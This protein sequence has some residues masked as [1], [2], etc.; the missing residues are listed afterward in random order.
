MANY[1]R[2]NAWNN[3]GT[4][5]SNDDLYWYAKGV[6]KMMSRELD[7]K[8][9]WWFY[10]GIHDVDF[11]MWA[12]VNQQ[13]DIPL[14]PKPDLATQSEFW[15]QC[16]HGT[17]YFL[18]WHRGYLMALEK[19]LRTDILSLGGPATWALPYWN[20]FGGGMENHIP[21]AFAQ[22]VLIDRETGE[23][24]ANPLYVLRRFG[25]EN[26]G[27]VYMPIGN[28]GR[29]VNLDCQTKELFTNTSRVTEY[30]GG[31]TGFAH[32]GSSTGANESNPHNNGHV[33]VGGTQTDPTGLM[34]YN[35]FAAMDPIFYMHHCE[36]DR[37]WA[38]W[39]GSGGKNPNVENWLKGPAYSGGRSFVM[40]QPDG[41]KW[42][43][44]PEDVTSLESLNYTYDDLNPVV[45]VSKFQLLS[46][47]LNKL[48]I[49]HDTAL[50][51]KNTEMKN[52]PDA[53]LLGSHT[54][55]LDLRG[56]KAGIKV[57]VDS[58][59]WKRVGE[60]LKNASAAKAPDRIFLELENVTGNHDANFIH[61]KA[62]GKYVGSRALF[63]L[64]SAS[65][66]DDHHAGSGLRLIFE[67]TELIDE[68]H[69]AGDLDGQDGLDIQIETEAE[70]PDDYKIT[71][72]RVSIYRE[73]H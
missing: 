42:V 17:W 58:K 40:P 38:E 11:E 20:Y 55:K 57:K 16:Q 45:F 4:L 10:G 3:G 30:G 53:E 73:S 37:I 67:I 66:K 15:R 9:S 47:R 39:N 65:K 36:I 1:V 33:N 70:V 27:N 68:L 14:D 69:L 8:T 51:E 26:N 28:E 12:T 32:E 22:E 72:E 25:P 41:S 56:K 62:N 50:L 2:R 60:S 46:E 29:E 21:P 34:S 52:E 43:Y 49:D 5:E 31:E 18:P 59:P 7:D 71:V 13:P 54:G 6:E 63:G 19:Q 23:S 44:I 24:S 64:N 48:G 35:E 61:V